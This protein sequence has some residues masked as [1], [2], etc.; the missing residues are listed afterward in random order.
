MI[1]VISKS[2]EAGCKDRYDEKVQ[3]GASYSSRDDDID[4]V[5]EE[6]SNVLNKRLIVG[7]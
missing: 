4:G 6:L 1:V 3:S 7:E 2:K 5:E